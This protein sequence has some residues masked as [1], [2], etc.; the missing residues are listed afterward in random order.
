MFDQ[1]VLWLE[2]YPHLG[3]AAVF[4]LCGM[5]LPLPEEI[6]LLAAGYVCAKL[7]LNPMFMFCHDSRFDAIVSNTLRKI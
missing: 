3:V 2:Q 6:V 1:I 4:L 5:G 7:D